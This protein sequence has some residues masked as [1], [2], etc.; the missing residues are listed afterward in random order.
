MH[1]LVIDHHSPYFIF[2]M[3]PERS[4]ELW[5]NLCVVS[6]LY[7]RKFQ[8]MNQQVFSADKS[9]AVLWGCS[10][11]LFSVAPLPSAP[12]WQHW[13]CCWWCCSVNILYIINIVLL[14]SLVCHQTWAPTSIW[15]L[16]S[17]DHRPFKNSPSVSETNSAVETKCDWMLIF[18]DVFFQI[19]CSL[20][21]VTS[22]VTDVR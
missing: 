2:Y 20:T 16:W 19:W 3:Y 13:F 9:S 22:D 1:T 17:R 8:E 21:I 7:P 11:W 18:G 5:A 12:W 10:L 14:C 4:K 15:H 6:S